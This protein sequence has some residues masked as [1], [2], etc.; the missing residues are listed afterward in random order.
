MSFLYYSIQ[1]GC[2][3]P[4]KIGNYYV[5]YKRTNDCISSA[6][7]L[8]EK[9]VNREIK[10]AGGFKKGWCFTGKY[11]VVQN[12]NYSIVAKILSNVNYMTVEY[13]KAFQNEMMFIRSLIVNHS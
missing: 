10:I 4:I 6:L 3:T 9:D 2:N 12:F 5:Y 8:N 1:N 11:F 13:E 7:T